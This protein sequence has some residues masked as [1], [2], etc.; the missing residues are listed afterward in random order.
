MQKKFTHVLKCESDKI[1]QMSTN[2]LMIKE[3]TILF[4]SNQ[5][6]TQA[7]ELLMRFDQ[8]HND[9]AKIMIFLHCKLIFWDVSKIFVSVSIVIPFR[10]PIAWWA[11]LQFMH[12][13]AIILSP[14]IGINKMSTGSISQQIVKM[15]T[16]PVSK[17]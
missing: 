16:Q 3:P 14:Q 11:C 8:I 5:S 2:V 12:W 17:L 13:K 1:W 15:C 7:I 9:V 4:D 10:T 6:D